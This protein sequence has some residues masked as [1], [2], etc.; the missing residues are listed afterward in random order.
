MNALERRTG[1]KTYVARR[2]ATLHRVFQ[3][4]D[5]S[6]C[7]CWCPARCIRHSPS[8][9][10]RESCSR[11]W[12]CEPRSVWSARKPRWFE[13]ALDVEELIQITGKTGGIDAQHQLAQLRIRQII[14]GMGCL[15]GHPW[16]YGMQTGATSCLRADFFF[17]GVSAPP[18]LEIARNAGPH[19][20]KKPLAC[21]RGW[22]EPVLR[23]V[24][25]F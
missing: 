11:C 24:R 8:A 25:A 9:A 15:L 17:S 7:A 13:H 1:S 5:R 18:L 16:W 20:S 3:R 2:G 10:R 4:D 21:A 12:H 6:G 19:G 14:H 22:Y 23:G